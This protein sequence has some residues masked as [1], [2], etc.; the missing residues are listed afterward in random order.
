MR[1]VTLDYAYYLENQDKLK[2]VPIDNG[3]GAVEP[4]NETI[5]SGEYAPFISSIIHLCS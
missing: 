5:E 3:K 2:I 1:L 4:N